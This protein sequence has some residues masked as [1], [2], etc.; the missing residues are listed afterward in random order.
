[1][2][3]SSVC[4]SAAGRARG[5]ARVAVQPH[6]LP[7]ERTAAPRAPTI[8]YRG[9]PLALRCCSWRCL[10]I[11]PG[12][13][14]PESAAASAS[15]LEA[16][17]RC[18]ALGVSPIV[19][20]A[21]LSS[22]ACA[23]CLSIVSPAIVTSPECPPFGRYVAERSPG[24]EAGILVLV[25]YDGRRGVQASACSLSGALAES[26][27]FGG[28]VPDAPTSGGSPA[29]RA[30]ANRDVGLRSVILTSG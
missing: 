25:L 17:I 15:P 10:G 12:A 29:N 9:G 6:L 13:A 28:E 16:L 4:A 1:M 21:C 27:R 23:L 18:R 2:R 22:P 19:E 5:R 8:P 14:S 26:L 20:V 3:E 7:R 30:C 11:P 24:V